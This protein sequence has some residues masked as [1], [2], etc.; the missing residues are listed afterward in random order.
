[1]TDIFAKTEAICHCRLVSD[2]HLISIL[3]FFILPVF[4]FRFLNLC[5][6]MYSVSNSDIEDFLQIWSQNFEFLDPKCK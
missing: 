5:N 4:P 1:M 3:S 2:C 6:C